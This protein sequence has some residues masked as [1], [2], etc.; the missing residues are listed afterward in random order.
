MPHNK[1]KMVRKMDRVAKNLSRL[2]TELRHVQR[3]DNRGRLGPTGH[4]KKL[5]DKPKGQAGRSELK[6]GYNLQ[7]AMGLAGDN[8]KY[9]TFRMIAQRY[10]NRY[11]DTEKNSQRAG[12]THRHTPFIIYDS[13]LSDGALDD[14][15]NDDEN[16]STPTSRQKRHRRIHDSDD[17][18]TDE[19]P[20]NYTTNTQSYCDLQVS[21][22]ARAKPAPAPRTQPAPV[23][24]TKPALKSRMTQAPSRHLDLLLPTP[25]RPDPPPATKLKPISSSDTRTTKVAT[26]AP[27]TTKPKAKPVTVPIPHSTR[28]KTKPK[29][30]EASAAHLKIDTAVNDD[31]DTYEFADLPL[32]CPNDNCRDLVPA[33]PNIELGLRLE[34]EICAALRQLRKEKL[35]IQR[36]KARGWPT[37]ITWETVSDR[38]LQME[39]ELNLMIH[40]KNTR[41][42][43]FFND[44]FLED[45]SST[46][47]QSDSAKR[48]F[49]KLAITS[50]QRI[51]AMV[52]NHARPG[53]Y[54]EKGKAIIQSAIFSMFDH[55]QISNEAFAPLDFKD[56]ECS[57][58]EAYEEM[59]ASADSGVSLHP[60]TEEDSRIE[61][62]TRQ[63]CV[64]AA[65][66]WVEKVKHFRKEMN[67]EIEK[68]KEEQRMHD[69]LAAKIA[70]KQ[71]ARKVPVA[72]KSQST[73]GPSKFPGSYDDAAYE[74]DD[75]SELSELPE[76]IQ[77]GE[78]HADELSTPTGS[79]S[80]LRS[81]IFGPSSLLFVSVLQSGPL[82]LLLGPASPALRLRPFVSAIGSFVFG[83]SSLALRLRPFVSARHFELTDQLQLLYFASCLSVYALDVYLYLPVPY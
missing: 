6:G 42:Y 64:M 1:G 2:E 76:S 16:T 55:E 51:P 45:L 49:S 70:A 31:D 69:N 80:A 58:E 41:R 9:N 17:S 48:E 33:D 38:V 50:R 62:I 71:R 24:R 43:S 46:G 36:A 54:G 12:Q 44:M 61:R 29:P 73:A 81:F 28:A 27:S 53:Y 13:D 7:Q 65:E 19:G 3:N 26:E 52:T 75:E 21:I 56:L 4:A 59:I 72:S 30:T 5:I 34:L 67:D 18:E 25:T 63:H 79:S 20:F 39:A 15:L 57:L 23:P 22:P 10:T 82:S 40:D 60:E 78:G 74:D 37:I 32:V 66:K 83:S 11:L 8:R 68:G 14:M 35:N 47:L 77:Q